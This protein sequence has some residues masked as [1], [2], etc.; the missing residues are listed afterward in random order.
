MTYHVMLYRSM[1]RNGF[2]L[3]AERSWVMGAG[4]SKILRMA[5]ESAQPLAIGLQIPALLRAAVACLSRGVRLAIALC[6]GL[7]L[8]LPAIAA[9]AAPGTDGLLPLS[10]GDAVNVQVFGQPDMTTT[11]Y[12]G[13]DGAIRVPL[14]GAVPVAGITPVEAAQRVEKALKD[15]EYLK[16]PHVTIAVVHSSN[17]QVSVLGEVREPGQYDIS[18][19]TT[20]LDILARAGG[21]TENSA[22]II[23]ILKRDPTGVMSRQ[24][25][26]VRALMNRDTS[27][28]S[29]ILSAGDSILVPRAQYFYIEGEINKP[30]KYRLD[31]QTTVLQAITL[32]GGVTAKGSE[33]R[34]DIKRLGKDGHYVSR[35]AKGSDL[36]Q[37]DDVIRVKESLF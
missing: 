23:Y 5:S 29:Q 33:R 22:D 6:A 26:N 20:L 34:I 1:A 11:V 27:A 37:P 3:N 2:H 24:P 19:R 10:P 31:D 36:V 14:A 13:K 35:H 8:A 4:Y 32:A 28:P 7:L 12:V 25:V 9:D 17:Q 15:G 30:D 21:L 16:D 18:G